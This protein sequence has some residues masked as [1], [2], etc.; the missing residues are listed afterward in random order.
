MRIIIS[1]WLLLANTNLVC[2]VDTIRLSLIGK[3]SDNGN[4]KL[5]WT[6]NDQIVW[7]EGLSRGYILEKAVKLPGV[8]LSNLKF[9]KIEVV[10][11]I[12]KDDWA[13]F[14]AE[15]QKILT[16]KEFEFIQTSYELSKSNGVMQPG[17]SF[18][19]AMEYKKE[20]NIAFGYAMIATMMNWEAAKIHG[21]AYDIK[22]FNR[23]EVYRIR[24]NSKI[25]GIE[26]LPAYFTNENLE[27]FIQEDQEIFVDEAHTKVGFSW[28]NPPE[29]FANF[30]E[31]STD[32][33]K[34]TL[35]SDVPSIKLSTSNVSADSCVYYVDGLV[36]NKQYYFKIYGQNIFGEKVL[37][38][39]ARG[40]PKDRIPPSRPIMLGVSHIEKDLVEI[41]WNISKEDTDVKGFIIGR[42]NEPT[43]QYYQIHEGIIPKDYRVFFDEYFNRD[44]TNY[45]VVESIDVTGNRSRSG[46]GYLTINDDDPPLKPVSLEGFMDSVGIVTL[47]MEPQSE[48]DFMGYRVYK[49]N[50]D[51]HEFSVVHE[52]YNDTIVAN[53]RN[54]ILIDTSTLESLTP[55][56]YYKVGALDYHY[57]ESPPSEIIKVPR[58][59]K[60]PPVPPLINDY[61]VFSKKV[62]LDI[63]ASTSNDVK[64]NALYRKLPNEEEWTF[65]DSLG[66][67]SDI[68][69]TDTSV[70][71]GQLYQYTSNAIDYS[72]LVSDFGNILNVRPIYKPRKLEM[73]I[74]CRY[75]EESKMILSSWEI[76][77][78][79]D[80]SVVHKISAIENG[81]IKNISTT[82]RGAPNIYVFKS[83]TA[84]TYLSIGSNTKNEQ[85]L[86]S[87]SNSCQIISEKIENDPL[88][89]TFTDFYIK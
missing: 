74:D 50:A 33:K 28:K 2:Q 18:K 38:G 60:Y 61:E 22:N 42:S 79:V 44:T 49:A 13:K 19:D 11:K 82:P 40:M 65:V 20:L 8:N 5:R 81:E 80:E 39:S 34:F 43:G 84:P 36:N 47:K 85:F 52:S 12:S 16:S 53:A 67:A 71:A 78:D 86:K 3:I 66:I 62:I 7:L 63:T 9:T 26:V 55:F 15:Y 27:E 88:Y 17:T 75:F 45:Y 69:F 57:N 59:D 56:V 10:E 14:S 24:L 64:Q 89:K 32:N 31:F 21:V 54:P 4:L 25:E 46:F 41:S 37:L 77:E 6:C 83:S 73:V 58:P 70:V 30:V 35:D 23:N 87:D 76:Q 72:G 68:R 29:I 51:D 1:I 48:K